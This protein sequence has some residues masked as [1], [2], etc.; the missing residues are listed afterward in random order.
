MPAK[1]TFRM[2]ERGGITAAPEFR[3][4]TALEFIAHYLDRIDD[5]LEK[6]SASAGGAQA[7]L[8]RVASEIDDVCRAIKAMK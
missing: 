4:A 5:H 1:Q 3:V 6:L 7:G 8:T 2:P